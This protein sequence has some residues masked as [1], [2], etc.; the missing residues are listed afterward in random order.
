[1][2]HPISYG[3]KIRFNFKRSSRVQSTVPGSR[4]EPASATSNAA[5]ATASTQ[6]IAVTPSG[7]AV[8]T[9]SGETKPTQVSSELDMDPAIIASSRSAKEESGG[10]SRKIQLSDLQSILGNLGKLKIFIRLLNL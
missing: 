5:S 3:V 2:Y 1:M 8:S 7:G 6:N 9:P 10:S 4:V